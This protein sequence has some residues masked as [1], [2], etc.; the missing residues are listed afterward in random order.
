MTGGIGNFKYIKN[1][2]S[3]I[4]FIVGVCKNYFT[5]SKH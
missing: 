4:N 5:R 3:N 1:E 2:K